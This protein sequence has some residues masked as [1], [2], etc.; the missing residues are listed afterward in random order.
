MVI[1]TMLMESTNT[2][3]AAK[4]G[5]QRTASHSN[6]G[7]SSANGVTVFQCCGGSDAVILAVNATSTS[8]T[9]PSKSSPH[10][11]GFRMATNNPI[12]R[13]PIVKNPTMWPSKKS[14]HTVGND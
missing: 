1:Q 2:P 14:S 9:A 3:A 4:T 13:G 5:R 12:T 7:K 11:G 8:A 10:D 6:S